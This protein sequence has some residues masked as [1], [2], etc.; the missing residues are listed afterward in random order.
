MIQYFI[1]ENATLLSI[2]V[3]PAE[4]KKGLGQIVLKEFEKEVF[5]ISN[6]V[7]LTTDCDNN[8]HVNRFYQNNNYELV[9]NFG[10]D[11]RRMNLYYKKK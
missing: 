10:Q 7:S 1:I 9:Q 11:E 6:G 8:D 4:G 2:C 5:L 3:D